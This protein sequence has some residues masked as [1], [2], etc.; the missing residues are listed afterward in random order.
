[1]VAEMFDIIQVIPEEV[2]I[3]VELEVDPSDNLASGTAYY[4]SAQRSNFNAQLIAIWGIKKDKDLFCKDSATGTIGGAVAS[5]ICKD[6]VQY[7]IG[8]V[9]FMV[10]H[11][12][13]SIGFFKCKHTPLIK[14][15]AGVSCCIKIILFLI[16]LLQN[17]SKIDS[18]NP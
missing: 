2:K 3:D 15:S 12:G 4:Q 8:K 18:N 10:Y 16:R 6:T 11:M 13:S 5:G 7:P 14:R 1:M 17:S 9:M